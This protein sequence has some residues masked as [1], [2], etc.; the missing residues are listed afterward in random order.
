VAEIEGQVIGMTCLIPGD[1]EAELEPI[2]VSQA[3]RG[4]GIGRRLVDVV[5]REARKSGVRQ[6]KVDPFFP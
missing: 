6:L 5:M 3:F 4:L 2:I 1:D